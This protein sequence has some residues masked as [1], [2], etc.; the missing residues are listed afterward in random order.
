MH[1]QLPSFFNRMSDRE[2][3]SL[4]LMSLFLVLTLFY[5]MLWE[6]L[7]QERERLIAKVE[8]DLHEYHWMQ[9]AVAV[10]KQYEMVSRK[11]RKGKLPKGKSLLGVVDAS[12]KRFKLKDSLRRIEPDGKHGVK[13]SF[14]EGA[15]DSLI[16]WLGVMEQRYG[17]EVSRMNITR[18]E[19]PGVVNARISLQVAG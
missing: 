17:V 19:G 10:W 16:K 3:L 18:Q 6:P 11:E 13:L 14:E 7:F 15:F 5:L 8:S 4:I 1:L 9:G 12:A 2:Q